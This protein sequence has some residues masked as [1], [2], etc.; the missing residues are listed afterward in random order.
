M[1]TTMS[2]VHIC[3]AMV[4][5][6]LT[7]GHKKYTV[8]VIDKELSAK[9]RK[10]LQLAKAADFS[11]NGKN[12]YCD[13]TPVPNNVRAWIAEHSMDICEARVDADV[14]LV[15]NVTK[16]GKR[17]QL[18]A[19]LK[20]GC[21][22]SANLKDSIVYKTALQSRRQLWISAKFRDDFPAATKILTTL[23]SRNSK[24]HVINDFIAFAEKCEGLQRKRRTC[25]FG[26]ATASEFTA[27]NPASARSRGF[28]F[29][30]F[31]EVACQIDQCRSALHC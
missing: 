24:W 4:H 9:R 3:L 19:G 20:G 12:I 6:H 2:T 29:G 23:V 13:I 1:T 14:Y 25:M 27:L 22:V 30:K 10:T 11:F 31:V 16:P 17:I 18:A 5:T 8:R 28:L 7:Y 26:L 21:L 15:A